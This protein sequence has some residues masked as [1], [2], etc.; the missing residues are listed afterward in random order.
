[1]V[2]EGSSLVQCWS[3]DAQLG[4]ETG[5][6]GRIL[7]RLQERDGHSKYLPRHLQ[8]GFWWL[9]VV[10]AILALLNP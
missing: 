10:A 7:E 9:R 3:F 6:G 1:M 5:N 2:D 8:S 4:A